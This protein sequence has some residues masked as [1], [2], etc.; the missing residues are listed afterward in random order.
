MV[1]RLEESVLLDKIIEL[2]TDTDKPL[3]TLLRQC[4]VLG[5]ELKNDSLK[6][7]ANQELNGYTDTNKVPEYRIMN[8]GA[9][10][11][12]NAGYAFPSITRSIPAM[13]MEKEHRWAAETVHLAE[14]VSAY[15][16]CLK[17]TKGHALTYQWSADMVVYYQARFMPGH[18][19]AR[20]WQ[21]IPFSPL[22]GML[23]TIRTRVLNV[24][25]D[26]KNEIGE[27]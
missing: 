23:N 24:A 17:S 12:F 13:G 10:G 25:L 19:L 4:V 22:A 8:A 27:S 21:E 16:N 9:Q 5:H 14:P 2:A 11:I 1:H 18:A 15:E 7:W 3:S 6:T 26:I 20:A